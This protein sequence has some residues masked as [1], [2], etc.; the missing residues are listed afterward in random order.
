MSRKILGPNNLIVLNAQR[1]QFFVEKKI[2]I[3]AV[4]VY[5]LVYI[6][7]VVCERLFQI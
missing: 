4:Y 6:Y 2:N 1:Q 7:Q 5:I 3:K